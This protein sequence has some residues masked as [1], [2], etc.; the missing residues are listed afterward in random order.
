MLQITIP[1]RLLWIIL[2][3]ITYEAAQLFCDYLQEMIREKCRMFP[4]VRL[5][6]DRMD[7][8]TKAEIDGIPLGES[9]VNGKKEVEFVT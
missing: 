5:P 6:D 2:Q 7:P 1:I 3:N 8:C 4:Y 9:G